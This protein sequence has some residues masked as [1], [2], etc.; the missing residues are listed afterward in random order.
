MGDAMLAQD[1]VLSSVRQALAAEGIEL[2]APARQVVLQE[3]LPAKDGDRVK[4]PPVKP[5]PQ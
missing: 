3:P 4:L 2:P 5:D 1:H